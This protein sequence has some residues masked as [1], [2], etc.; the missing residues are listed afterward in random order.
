MVYFKSWFDLFGKK[1]E[2]LFILFDILKI[3]RPLKDCVLLSIRVKTDDKIL[4]IRIS[5]KKYK[6]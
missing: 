6:K 2:T 1:T 3:M 5:T 4:E